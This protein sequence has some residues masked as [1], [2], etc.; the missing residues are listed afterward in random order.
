MKPQKAQLSTLF[1]ALMFLFS[2]KDKASVG[3][4]GKEVANPDSA[5]NSSRQ[6]MYS[7]T[8]SERTGQRL[9]DKY[10]VVCHGQDGQGDGFNAYNLEP[11][12]RNL[13][14]TT[15]MNKLSDARLSEIV[16]TGG[17]GTGK[18]A[19]MPA[20]GSTLSTSEVKDLVNYIRY[21]SRQ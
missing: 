15:Y 4:P 2:C 7:M 18:S 21:L 1:L 20:Y 10:C 11:R 17:R 12:P 14:D 19:L 6:E 9:F 5:K 8:H 13:A 16:S 3:I